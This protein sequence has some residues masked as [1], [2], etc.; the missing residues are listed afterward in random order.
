MTLTARRHKSN[1]AAG[2]TLLELVVV[3]TILVLASLISFP[4]LVRALEQQKLRQAA[5]EL[6]SMLLQARSLAQRQQG[7]CG[8]SYGN[9]TTVGVLARATPA[10]NFS[11]TGTNANRCIDAADVTSPPDPTRAVL[12]QLP[13]TQIT[14]VRGLNLSRDVLVFNANG[15]TTSTAGTCGSATACAAT[16][17]T[18]GL[19]SGN[20]QIIYLSGSGTSTQYC[21]SLGLNLN[22]VGFRNGSSGACIYSRN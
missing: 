4:A 19:L 2:F 6:Q 9:D 3:A 7:S 8:I 1:Q 12:P 18:L 5:M 16:F 14:G 17:N 15:T 20:R 10:A 11:G 21:V 13:L 22:R